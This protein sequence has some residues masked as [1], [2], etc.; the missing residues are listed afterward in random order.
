MSL[1]TEGS[2]RSA[3]AAEWVTTTL[4]LGLGEIGVATDTGDIRV[5]DGVNQFE[6]LKTA[7]GIRK[8]RAT[9]VAGT[10]TVA[11]TTITATTII[12][13]QHQTLGTVTA[14]KILTLTRSAGV[15]FTITSTDNTDTS[16]IGYVLI[17]V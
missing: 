15:S 7:G 8:G 12:L 1:E 6:T 9:L 17:E 13:A 3:T 16:V 11:N 14:A 10:V 5:G 4:V 2:I